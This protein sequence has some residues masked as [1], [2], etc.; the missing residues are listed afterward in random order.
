MLE[1]ALAP[2][3]RN[4]Y[5]YWFG[6]Y[7]QFRAAIGMEREV[8][9]VQ[10]LLAFFMNIINCSEKDAPLVGLIIFLNLL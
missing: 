6:R 9:T 10:L 2:A 4:S 3:T 1:E 5:E 8:L 7:R